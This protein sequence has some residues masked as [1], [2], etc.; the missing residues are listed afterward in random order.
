MFN[1]FNPW[2][3][4]YKNQN[5]FMSN[6]FNFMNPSKASENFEN[7]NKMFDFY[8]QQEQ[9]M[10]M[11]NKF[12]KDNMMKME[13]FNPYFKEWQEAMM[14]YDPV[15]VSK[16]MSKTASDVYDKM[17]NS[18]SFYLN[19]YSVWE[20]INKSILK[21]NSE[22]FKQ[23]LEKTMDNYDKLLMENFLPLM[24]KE[25]QG[26]FTNPY[27]YIK[28]LTNSVNNL[29]EPWG[30]ISTDLANIYA[31]ASFKDPAKLSE[32]LKLWKDG[33]DQTIGALIKSPVVGASKEAIEQNNKM[34]DALI[35]FLVVSAEFSSKLA[36][37]ANENSKKAF[38]NYFELLEEGSEPKSFNEFYK[39][40]SKKVEKAI[41]E[42]F[43]TDE[44]SK[45]I[46][47]LAD[48]GM[49]FKIESDK[50]IE[51]FLEGYPIVTNA[52]IDSVYKN[53]YELKK[54]V[55]KLKKELDTI[56]KDLEASKK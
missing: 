18:N 17:M 24:P 30:K 46:A 38:E 42:Y 31:E 7:F 15:K 10:E 40:W 26:L 21:P 47:F 39:F 49:K 9:M 4:F 28:T 37:I 29:Y 43:Y 55:K 27:N 6:Y 35:N 34:I 1:S 50:T 48:S 44:F 52:E 23:E 41:D 54:E 33:Y 45:M 5:D 20:N 11:W 19:L 32:A 36:T 12:A 25:Y 51:K 53:V 22:L 2:Q 16:M 8:K 3:E 56:K 13:D 14:S